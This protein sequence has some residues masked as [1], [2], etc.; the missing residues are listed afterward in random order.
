MAVNIVSVNPASGAQGISIH[1]EISAVFDAPLDFDTI[2]DGTFFV[3]G[4]DSKVASGPFVPLRSPGTSWHEPLTS[5]AYYNPVYGR[6]QSKYIDTNGSDLPANFSDTA[7]TALYRT[8]VIFLPNRPLTPSHDYILYICGTATSQATNFGISRRTVYDRMP[9]GS[10]ANTSGVFLEGGYRGS[11]VGTMQVQIIKSGVAGVATYKWRLGNG[12]YSPETITHAAR[13]ALRDNVSARFSLEGTH[14]AGDS[15]S[16]IIKPGDYLAQVNAYKFKTGDAGTQVAPVDAS[17]IS[18]RI[19]PSSPVVPLAGPGL[20]GPGLQLHH[21]YP[22]NQASYIATSQSSFHFYFNQA[23]ST[24]I[25]TLGIR[26]YVG[27][28]NGDT[29]LFSETSYHPNHVSVV[30]G[31]ELIIYLDQT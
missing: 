24:V 2:G 15:F 21:T 4:K 20:A 8:K 30:N 10:N 27:P 14:I 7:G 23:I 29:A 19:A 12:S 22:W 6:Y 1:H 5:P 3:E 18:S 26:A 11:A 9:A 16:W 17:L 13:R 28:A 31:T 25:D